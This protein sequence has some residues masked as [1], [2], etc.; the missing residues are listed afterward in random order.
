MIR[1]FFEQI[2]KYVLSPILGWFVLF[3]CFF[4][5]TNF[6]TSSANFITNLFSLLRILAYYITTFMKTVTCGQI[7][8]NHLA[9]Q[10]DC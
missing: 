6:T 9:V 4:Q 7:I 2:G 10:H 1:D 3:V 8:L 5:T